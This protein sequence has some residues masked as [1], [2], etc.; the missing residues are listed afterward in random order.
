MDGAEIRLAA[1]H[2]VNEAP[3]KYEDALAALEEARRLLS[4][5]RD[6]RLTLEGNISSSSEAS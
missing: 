6:G 1:I 4:Y 2:L 5:V 3:P